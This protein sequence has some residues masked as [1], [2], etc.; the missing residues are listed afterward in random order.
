[1]TRLLPIVATLMLVAAVGVG[2]AVAGDS[3]YGGPPQQT[4]NKQDMRQ[5]KVAFSAYLAGEFEVNDEGRDG[6]GDPDAKGSATLLAADEDT[7]CYAVTLRGSQPPAMLHI[8]R[9][10]AGQNGDVVIDLSKNVPKNASGNPAGNPGASSGC[11]TLQGTELEAFKRILS[12]P[13][14]YYV[15]V[16]TGPDGLFPKGIARGQLN[17]LVYD[18][19]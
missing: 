13:Q 1:M 10:P 3:G 2:V 8:H 6:A 5:S 11:K 18:N 15:N 9:G 12:N 17:R 19:G 7:L 16:H 4:A 14:N